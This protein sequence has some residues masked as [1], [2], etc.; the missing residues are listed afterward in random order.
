VSVASVF[1]ASVLRGEAVAF[2]CGGSSSSVS[3]TSSSDT[4]FVVSDGSS[5]G[6]GSST[7]SGSDTSSS[8]GSESFGSIR[9]SFTGSSSSEGS[10]A[11]CSGD[12]GFKG[13][14]DGSFQLSLSAGF[15]FG[16]GSGTFC[17]GEGSGASC[18]GASFS[19]EPG[20]EVSF[21]V[22]DMFC[23][24]DGLFAYNKSVRSHAEADI[25]P[26]GLGVVAAVISSVERRSSSSE[27]VIFT[28]LETLLT[29][30]VAITVTISFNY[31]T[32]S[33]IFSIAI[34]VGG[35]SQA[36]KG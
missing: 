17:S 19:G 22:S 20:L 9:S 28:T 35:S 16:E 26:G 30:V 27:A 31:V 3:G 34:G 4:S 2:K 21:D 29:V 15:S 36:D 18:S 32:A 25:V 6:K 23:L 24:C 8:F 14:V 33:T 11:F 10:D 5:S 1:T 13:S 7:S 12:L